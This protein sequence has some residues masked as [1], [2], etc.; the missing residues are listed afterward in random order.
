MFGPPLTA[1][2]YRS[3]GV[4]WCFNVVCGP[5]G[6]GA[7]VLVRAL[8]PTDG[9]EIMGR[10]RQTNDPRLLCAGP[11]RLTQALAIDRTLD[12]L[13]LGA[14]PFDLV[15]AGEPATLAIGPRI[16]ITKAAER[17]WRFGLAGSPYLSRPFR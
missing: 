1:Y 2:V 12:G 10:R 17:P 8:Q 7:A 15:A 6:H 13:S 3:Y 11:G 16:G 5:E 14:S 9:L 4:H